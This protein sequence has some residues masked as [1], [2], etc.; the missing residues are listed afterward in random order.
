MH[1]KHFKEYDCVF[2]NKNN[3]IE[4]YENQILTCRYKYNK[5][6]KVIREDNLLL[7]MS[8]EYKYNK[9][10]K[11]IQ[12]NTYN[13]TLHNLKNVKSADTFTYDLN[14]P[15]LITSYNNEQFKYDKNGNLCLYRDAKLKKS[16]NKLIKLDNNTFTYDKN[17]CR[18]AKNV[19]RTTTKFY[20]ENNLLIKQESDTTLTFI[21]TNNKI[22]GFIYNNK[23]YFYKFN[24][25]NDIVGIY[26]SNYILICRYVYDYFGNHKVIISNEINYT[27]AD[28]NPFRF[29]SHYYDIETGLYY[30]NGRY[31]DAEIGIF[32]N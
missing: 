12:R 10:D 1:I 14:N 3:L 6:S 15:T 27:L 28:T 31:Y 2:D 7:N 29:H 26:N 22:Q 23:K 4:V 25:N 11:L 16:N 19:G 24:Y 9:F 17:N 13:Y 18:T 5:H 32:I 21:Y 30:I 20:L 8:F